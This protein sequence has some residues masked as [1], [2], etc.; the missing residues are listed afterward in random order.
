[1]NYG[2]SKRIR[3]WKSNTLKYKFPIIKRDYYL[4][5][6]RWQISISYLIIDIYSLQVKYTLSFIIFIYCTLKF[7][8]T[9][10]IYISVKDNQFSNR[11]ISFF[12][13]ENIGNNFVF[14]SFLN[15]T[16]IIEIFFRPEIDNSLASSIGL[17]TLFNMSFILSNG[18]I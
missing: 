4:L 17:L 15:G 16:E 10:L 11:S 1:M 5:I 2:S 13:D 12:N 7:W 14:E 8:L 6:N 18:T 9:L 3:I